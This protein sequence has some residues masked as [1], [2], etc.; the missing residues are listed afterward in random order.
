MTTCPPAM[1]GASSVIVWKCRG[2]VIA[3]HRRAA[4][5]G[6]PMAPGQP[7]G[8]RRRP[9]RCREA[10]LSRRERRQQRLQ[11]GQ[12]PPVGVGAGAGEPVVNRHEDASAPSSR[13]S[14]S[15]VAIAR[16]TCGMV[17]DPPT[18][19]ATV[20]VSSSSSNV[21]PS[22]RHRIHMVGDAVV[23]AQH[24]RRTRG[25]AA[26]SCARAARRA[27]RPGVEAKKRLISRLPAPSRRSF[28]R[29]RTRETSSAVRSSWRSLVSFCRHRH[30]VPDRQ[31]HRGEAG[32]GRQACAVA[33]D[34]GRALG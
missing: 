32:I 8:R 33:G 24:E 10:P 34:D 17:I 23:A 30:A 12:A 29:S 25:P 21:T 2:A 20:N 26:P 14:S 7:D 16:A 13:S 28:M 19:S 27:R 5:R 11:V 22:S 4:A 9:G 3:A 6:S 18:T 15:S 31:E 1:R